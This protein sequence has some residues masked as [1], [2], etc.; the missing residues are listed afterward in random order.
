MT[1][2]LGDASTVRCVSSD[3]ICEMDFQTKGFFS[4]QSNSVVGKIKKEST[5]EILYEISGQWSGELFIN[6]YIAPE[7]ST[8]GGLLVRKRVCRCILVYC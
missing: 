2:E 6:K 8:I 7:K 1:L 3:L 4:G 5:Q